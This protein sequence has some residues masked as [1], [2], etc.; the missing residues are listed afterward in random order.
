MENENDM[1]AE[2][3]NSSQTALVIL[4]LT[5][6]VMF[7][8][9]FFENLGK[10]LYSPGGYSGLINGYITNGQAPAAWKTVMAFMASHASVAAPLQG[11]AEL[12]FGVLLLSG[13]MTRL[14]AFAAFGFLSSLWVSEWGTAWIWELLVPM[15]VAVSLI[16][17]AAGRK[18]GVDSVMARKYPRLPIW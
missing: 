15:M 1:N 8:W 11:G 12:S 2:G 6:G 10:G 17:G 14:V 7:V 4:R 18:W 9:T 13:F 16:V 3:S 5:L